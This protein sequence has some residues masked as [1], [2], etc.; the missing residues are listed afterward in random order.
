MFS[1]RRAVLALPAPIAAASVLGACSGESDP[2]AL[3]IV[4]FASPWTE[5]LKDLV[6]D[7][8]AA[9]G[10]RVRIETYGNE[11]LNA[12][13][14]TRLN[15]RSTDF[16]LMV[17]QTQ[18]V[19][20]DYSRNLWLADLTERVESDAA[21]DWEDFQAQARDAVSLDGRVFGVPVMTERHIMYYRSD[22]LDAAGLDVPQTFTEL[23]EAV[24]ALHD[25]ANGVHGIALRGARVPLVTQFSS[26]LY[27]F[28]GDFQDG[29][30][31][32]AVDTPEAIEA[33]RFYGDLLHDFGP[34]GATNMGWVEASAIFAQGGAAFYLDADSQAYT[35]LDETASAVVDTV[36]YAR[37]PAGP[38]GSHPY[39]IVPAA[40]GVNAFSEKQDQAWAFL[41]WAT[42]AENCIRLLAE[43]TAPSARQSSWDDPAAAAAYPAGL[44]E[45]IRDVDGDYVGHDRP[46]LEQVARAREYV[47]G[48]AVTAI[49][50]GDVE[51]AAKDANEDFQTLLDDES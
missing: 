32:A 43:E 17:F 21:W 35:F 23:R 27:G 38:A 40:V 10:V 7:Y 5:G 50:G 34:P 25:P 26:F 42:G 4:T 51:A 33:Y 39:N 11:Q 3:T 22:L 36:A 44:V 47:G 15:A 49:E 48:P 9:E 20:R 12:T 18:D 24:A 13:Y 6:E 1:T 41:K 31:N 19:L 14:R 2:N 37:F 28:G 8:E 30:G 16:D 29:D 46:R 45:I